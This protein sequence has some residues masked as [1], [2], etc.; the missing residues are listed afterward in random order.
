MSLRNVS[1]YIRSVS[2][3]H[4]QKLYAE[5]EKMQNNLNSVTILNLNKRNKIK[6]KIL[7]LQHDIDMRCV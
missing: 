7:D 4:L 5:I 2:Y 6:N 1:Y 3:T